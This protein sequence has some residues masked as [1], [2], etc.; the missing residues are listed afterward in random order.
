MEVAE[1]LETFKK[2]Y[3]GRKDSFDKAVI[4]LEERGLIYRELGFVCSTKFR[5]EKL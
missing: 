3:G 5:K 2:R 4:A 1:L